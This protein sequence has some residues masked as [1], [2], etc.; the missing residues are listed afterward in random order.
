MHRQSPEFS[1]RN[2]RRSTLVAGLARTA[3]ALSILGFGAAAGISQAVAQTAVAEIGYVATMSGPV[4]LHSGAP[5]V[6]LDPLDVIPDRAR[7]ELPAGSEVRICHY[8]TERLLTLKGPLRASV[9][10][11]GVTAENGRP[12][13]PSATPC[14]APRVSKHQGGLVARGVILTGAR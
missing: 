6:L 12:L 9:S 7:L 5:P 10:A 3:M 1:G 11:H 14:T 4:V 8:P 2:R 13:D